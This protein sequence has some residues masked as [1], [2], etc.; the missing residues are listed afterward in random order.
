MGQPEEL[1]GKLV[2]IDERRSKTNDVST[3]ICTTKVLFLHTNFVGQVGNLR[4]IVNRPVNN[5]EFSGRRITNPPQVTNL[6]HTISTA[7]RS[8]AIQA[9]ANPVK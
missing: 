4:P 1:A 8:L 7:P 5:S 2:R 9:H 6:P 3:L